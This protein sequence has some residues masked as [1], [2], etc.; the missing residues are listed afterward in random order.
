ML[1]LYSLYNKWLSDEIVKAQLFIS[2][3]KNTGILS[4]QTTWIIISGIL[5]S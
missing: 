2:T 3:T 4:F 5:L 1:I